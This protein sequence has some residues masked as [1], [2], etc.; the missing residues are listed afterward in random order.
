LAEGRS[1][2]AFKSWLADR[3][4]A[5]GDA[6]D[7]VAMDGFT[8]FKTATAGELPDATAVMDPFPTD[9]QAARLSRAFRRRRACRSRGDLGHR[10]ASLA[11]TQRAP[12]LC[13]VAS[14]RLVGVAVAG[15]AFHTFAVVS[16]TTASTTAA[17]KVATPVSPATRAK[18]VGVDEARTRK[19]QSK[20]VLAKV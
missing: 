12:T 16:S 19:P 11:K 20:V 8:G 4:E 15:G 1:K 7:L 14:C 2:H 5:L 6:V 10:R 13:S 3:D 17:A 9:K 18:L